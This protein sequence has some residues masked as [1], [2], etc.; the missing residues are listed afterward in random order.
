MR[1]FGEK[2]DLALVGAAP[3]S[4]DLVREVAISRARVLLSDSG[5]SAL[6]DLQIIP[7]L[8][9]QLPDLRVLLIGMEPD[10]ATFLRAVRAGVLGYVLKD[11]S[12]VDVAVAVRSVAKNEAVCPPI[13]CRAL[14]EYVASPQTEAT[15]LQA[16][17]PFGLTRREQ[18]LV[19][20]MGRGLTNRKSQINS[21][22]RIKRSK[23]TCTGCC[24]RSALAIDWKPPNYADQAVMPPDCN[25]FNPPYGMAR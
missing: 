22:S 18:Q 21:I 7:E 20:M 5:L 16:R 14:F 11:A 8:R 1:I 2:S 15:C 10:P 24:R 17:H 6:S 25:L 3:F 4:P 23:T 12:S 19:E 13:L 9:K